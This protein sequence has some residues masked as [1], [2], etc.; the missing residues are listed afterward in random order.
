MKKYFIMAVAVLASLTACQQNE[1]EATYN[2]GTIKFAMAQTRAGVTTTENL[3]DFNVY[4]Y[5]EGATTLDIF[6]ENTTANKDDARSV[7]T[8]NVIKYW[9]ENTT[10]NFFAVYAPTVASAANDKITSQSVN[11]SDNTMTINFTNEKGEVDLVTAADGD[12]ATLYKQQT[13]TTK[14]TFKHALARVAFQFKWACN[15]GSGMTIEV[16][17]VTLGGTKKTGVLT[18]AAEGAQSW[19][20]TDDIVISYDAPGTLSED[21]DAKL[22]PTINND[23][24]GYHYIIPTSGVAPTISFNAVVKDSQNQIVKTYEVKDQA[25][26]AASNN[27]NVKFEPGASYHYTMNINPQFQI[28]EFTVEVEKWTDVD[29]GTIDFGN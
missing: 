13:N 19:T 14:L 25:L 5:T 12:V 26:S 3:A 28:I 15:A 1:P 27:A 21:E 4:G 6:P 8:P 24:T 2:D 7:W 11:V 18:V 29:A 16:S 23:G 20:A 17:D 9:A 10:Y 22:L